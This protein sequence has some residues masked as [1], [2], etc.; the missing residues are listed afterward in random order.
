LSSVGGF[1]S[2]AITQ[3]LRGELTNATVAEPKS[4]EQSEPFSE[5]RIPACRLWRFRVERL[6]RVAAHTAVRMGPDWRR[7]LIARQLLVEGRCSPGCRNPS[8]WAA[9]VRWE[10]VRETMQQKLFGCCPI[11][12][13]A[14]T[15][16]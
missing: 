5:I 3:L 12:L 16:N 8:R 7:F 1:P 13:R 11:R 4:V 14:A 15:A 6:N 9:L 2:Q 10:D